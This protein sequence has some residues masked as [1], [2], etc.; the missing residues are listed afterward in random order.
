M[1]YVD[2]MIDIDIDYLV[3]GLP[4]TLCILGSACKA[5]CIIMNAIACVEED[6]QKPGFKIQM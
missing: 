1:K 3:R 4:T 2:N 5:N 6:G